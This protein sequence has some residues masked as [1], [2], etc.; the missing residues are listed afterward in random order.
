MKATTSKTVAKPKGV[1]NVL[2]DRDDN[3]ED[4]SFGEDVPPTQA[5]TT[6]KKSASETYTKVH[7]S[8][9]FSVLD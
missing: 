2:V 8:Y 3:V 5:V 6:K 1:K 9:L 4:D 7:C